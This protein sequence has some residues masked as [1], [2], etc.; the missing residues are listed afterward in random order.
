MEPRTGRRCRGC[1]IET[2]TA[3]VP[4]DRFS[5]LGTAGRIRFEDDSHVA[6]TTESE[7][8]VQ[9]VGRIVTD[10]GQPIG[11]RVVRVNGP[12][13][14]AADRVER[15]DRRPPGVASWE[16]DVGI[17]DV[18]RQPLSK[19]VLG[20]PP[21]FVVQ[22]PEHR[23]ERTLVHG[24]RPPVVG[25]VRGIDQHVRVRETFDR[26]LAT[27]TRAQRAARRNRAPGGPVSS[28]GSGRPATST[29]S[30]RR[31]SHRRASRRRR[32]RRGTGGA[33]RPS[34]GTVS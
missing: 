30:T 17:G 20:S 29:G 23:L 27:G 32:P 25:H 33:A 8:H 15:Q 14:I 4:P 13:P 26:S 16:I 6:S 5:D 10:G 34:S 1:F 22:P 18:R 28:G 19:R 31:A 2:T 7:D 3:P 12:D 21:G 11:S 9:S 24:E